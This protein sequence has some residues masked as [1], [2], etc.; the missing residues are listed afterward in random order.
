MNILSLIKFTSGGK[1]RLLLQTEAA[2]CGLACLGMVASFH[3][4]QSDL[5]SLRQQF[6]LSLKGVTLDSIIKMADSLGFSSRPLRLEL[7]ELDQLQLP[8]I[9]HWDLNHF[10]VLKRVNSKYAWILDPAQGERK[11][12]L[13]EISKHFTGIALELIPS[14]NFSKKEVKATMTLSSF[15]QKISGLK[16]VLIQVFL[17]SFLL[18]LFALASPFFMQ[19][20][21]DDILISQDLDL[22]FVVALSFLLLAIV[23]QATS[24]LR[25]FVLLHLSNQLSVQMTR[26][27]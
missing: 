25:S 1:L 13:S 6:S 8:T 24:T 20:V 10:V 3:G 23:S 9:L 16:R 21:M 7:N 26:A 12:L 5:V 2:E 19:I 14:E 4:Y 22:L 11:L 17:L 15:W 27:C 18:Q